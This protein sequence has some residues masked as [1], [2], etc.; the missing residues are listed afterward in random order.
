MDKL[1]AILKRFP[2]NTYDANN[3]T[4]ALYKLIK[5]I[6]DEFII[7]E[8][9]IDRVDKMIGINTALP[10]DIY[11]R[12]GALLNIKQ[13]PGETDEQYKNRLKTSVV[14]LSGGTADAIKYAIACGLGT[15]N[16][17][18][19]MDRIRIYDAWKYPGT[20][21]INRDYGYVVCEIDLNQDKY[22]K[23]IEDIVAESANN[24]KASGVVI[25][26][27]Y[28]NYRIVYYAELDD[29]TYTSLSTSTYSQVG[30]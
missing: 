6:V 13:N 2:Q 15:N 29:I 11:N 18:A 9:N 21:N 10:D 28:H 12:F 5:A 30:E 26:F 19:A 1:E 7:T 16:D 3:S 22:S 20:D 17:P 27:I 23:E 24:V 25:Q 8:D 4:L 14:A